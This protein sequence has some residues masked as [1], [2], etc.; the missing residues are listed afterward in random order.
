MW[1]AYQNVELLHEIHGGGVDLRQQAH[2]E[3]HGETQD[4][5]VHNVPEQ[6]VFYT[7]SL[8]IT[9]HTQCP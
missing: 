9:S 5:P 6:N 4:H 3:D 7:M 1:F 2:R 8:N